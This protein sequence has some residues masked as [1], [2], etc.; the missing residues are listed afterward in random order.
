M[1]PE[2]EETTPGLNDEY[3]EKEK[4]MVVGFDLGIDATC[5]TCNNRFCVCP[6]RTSGGDWVEIN[7]DKAMQEMECWQVENHLRVCDKHQKESK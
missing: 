2:Q 1:D 7:K 3:T 6:E 4:D 5:E